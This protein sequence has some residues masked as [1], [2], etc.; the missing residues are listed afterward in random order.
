VLCGCLTNRESLRAAES[1]SACGFDHRIP[2]STLDDFLGT[3]SGDEVADLRRQL[4]APV[5][6]DWRRKALEP[7]GWPC[8]VVA[9]DHTTR[10][11][12]PV[13]HAH[14]PQAQVVHQQERPAYAQVRAVRTVLLSAVSKPAIDQVAIRASTNEGGMF[15]EVLQVLEAT[16]GALM[17]IYRLDAG[18]CSPAKAR[19][20]AAAHQ[21][22]SRGLTGHQPE[23]WCEAE[24][25]LGA[26][27]IPAASSAW[28]PDQGDQLRDHLYRTTAR[29]AYLDWSHLKQVWRMEQ[30][31]RQGKTGQVAGEHRDDV[32][33]RHRGRL[34][35]E[36]ILAMVRAHGAIEHYGHW[37]VDVIWDEDCKVGCGQGV[38]LQVRGLWRL[39]A[40]N[41][42]SRLRGRDLCMREQRRAEQRRWQACCE[43]LLLLICQAGRTLFPHRPAIAGL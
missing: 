42:G 31:M 36:Q 27:T 33:H 12:G 34:R 28:E 10:W 4:H 37:T 6:P 29:E 14:D 17:E 19:L 7:V 1:F 25:V 8:G 43:A 5:R 38:G 20:M 21:G 11:T 16:Y 41:V 3:F 32:T 13:A 40:Y 15:P 35:P 9:V 2:D 24:R 23:L 22:Y 18:F 26:Q 39:M 30:A